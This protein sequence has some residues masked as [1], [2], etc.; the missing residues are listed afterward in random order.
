MV[1]T[2]VQCTMCEKKVLDRNLSKHMARVHDGKNP[3]ACT[4]CKTVFSRKCFLEIHTS[5]F[6]NEEINVA[7][8]HEDKNIAIVH[9]EEK[10]GKPKKRPLKVRVKTVEEQISQKQFKEN[11]TENENNNL[12]EDIKQSKSYDKKIDKLNKKI[13]ALKKQNE[14]ANLKISE[15]N[16]SNADLNKRNKEKDEKIL[17][18][19]KN[20][21]G[22]QPNGECQN[23]AAA[24]DKIEKLYGEKN[25]LEEKV[26]QLEKLQEFDLEEIELE[27]LEDAEN[28]EQLNDVL[29]NLCE[30][31]ICPSSSGG[32]TTNETPTAVNEQIKRKRKISKVNEKLY[33]CEICEQEFSIAKNLKRHIKSVHEG[34][35]PFI[36]SISPCKQ[37]FTQNANLKRHISSFHNKIKA[38]KCN[39]CPASFVR[40]AGLANHEKNVH[41]TNKK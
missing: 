26:S 40:K 9:E 8:V 20:L 34:K 6:H 35:K 2:L 39:K 33:P 23:C 11:A 16:Q 21:T 3:L 12:K 24:Y 37:A 4:K 10:K 28:H 1:K 17:E 13:S 14:S 41:T 25:T 18:L 5:N 22:R 27:D 15:M 31:Q 29:P 30:S 32:K 7:T 38:F 19:E 36:C